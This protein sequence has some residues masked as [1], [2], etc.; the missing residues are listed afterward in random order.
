MRR[1]LLV[2]VVASPL[3]LPAAGA[4]ADDVNGTFTVGPPTVISITADDD[5]CIIVLDEAFFPEGDFQGTMNSHFRIEHMGPCDQPAPET[6]EAQ[7]TFTGS[8]LGVTGS[9]RYTFEGAIDAQGNAHG[10]L[11]ILPKTGTGGLA[12]LH[13]KIEFM[14]IRGVGGTYSGDV[15]FH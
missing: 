10:T 2:L 8:V 5:E 6:F 12:G 3:L 4:R 9:F 15:E 1:L 14:G 11:H 7:G 13:G